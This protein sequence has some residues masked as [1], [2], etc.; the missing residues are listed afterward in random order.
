MPRSKVA[1][2]VI[3]VAAAFGTASTAQGTYYEF[4]AQ[5]SFIGPITT[6]F[7]QGLDNAANKLEFETSA[8]CLSNIQTVVS[9]GTIVS[10][11]MPFSKVETLED[12]R[13]PVGKLRVML[14]GQQIHTEVFCEDKTFQA[15]DLPWGAGNEVPVERDSSSIISLAGIVFIPM[16]QGFF[17]LKTPNTL[18]PG[19][20]N[21][22]SGSGVVHGGSSAP[23]MTGSEREGF[24]SSV[25]R[26]WN[27]EPDSE[28]A[29]VQ[30][31]VSFNLDESGKVVGEVR[32]VASSGGTSDVEKA[33]FQ[34]ARDAILNCQGPDGYD[35]P[36]TKYD[37]WKEIEFTFDPSELRMR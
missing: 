3:L 22:P 37:Q 14:D 6:S 23:P 26:C 21:E 15:L 19:E 32:Q 18:F 20:V 24:R 8:E 34:T 36:I 7:L 4:A 11:L 16:L 9:L 35:L 13:G 17:D 25:A 29:R 28:A 31:T 1:P 33:A 5:G 27:P 10:D 2:A 12:S 30:I